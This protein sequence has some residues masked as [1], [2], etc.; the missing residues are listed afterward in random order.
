MS[1]TGYRVINNKRQQ[2]NLTKALQ[3]FVSL[4]NELVTLKD[5]PFKG[6]MYPHSRRQSVTTLIYFYF[7]PFQ[8]IRRAKTVVSIYLQHLSWQLAEVFNKSLWK[9][10]RKGGRPFCNILK[11]S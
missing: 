6:Y 9:E 2:R 11:Y 5:L 4:Y 8:I 10:R 7:S 1:K 3:F